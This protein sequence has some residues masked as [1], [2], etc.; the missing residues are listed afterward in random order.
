VEAYSIQIDNDEDFLSPEW[1]EAVGGADFA[2]A[3]ALGGG[4]YYWRVR[5]SNGSEV[6]T[7][8]EGWAFTVPTPT[9][10]GFKFYLPVVVRSHP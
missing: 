5:G 8:S 10:A 6:G 9:P 4:T 2:P 3:S 7:W 1:D